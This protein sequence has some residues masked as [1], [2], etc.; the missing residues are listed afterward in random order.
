MPSEQNL[1]SISL[2]ADASIG[3]L[4]GPPGVPGSASPNYG[5]QYCFVKVTGTRQ[6]GLAVAAT[7][8]CAGILQNKPQHPGDP[9]TVGY[10]GVS[11]VRVAG[12]ISAGDL[13]APNASGL[14]VTD[15]VNGRW[16]ALEP[17][18]TANQVISVFKVK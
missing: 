6:V 2:D 12:A 8:I 17:A 5:K 16:Q 13:V 15:N 7:D 3:I 18:T 9:A 1:R 11:Q 14:A 10:E 4:T